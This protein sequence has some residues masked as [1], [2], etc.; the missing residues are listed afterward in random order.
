M[1]NFGKIKAIQA[2]KYISES[3]AESISKFMEIVKNSS[4]LQNEF[5]IYKSLENAHIPNE[6]LAI[7]HIDRN[8]AKRGVLSESELEKIQKFNEESISIDSTKE[9]LYESI[10]TLLHNNIDDPDI[11]HNAYMNV[12]NHIQNNKPVEIN[13]TSSF[14]LPENVNSELIIEMAVNKF[15]EKYSSMNEDEKNLFNKLSTANLEEKKQIF[16]SLKEET[17]KLTNDG[18]TN[19]IEDKINEAIESI[20]NL[21]FDEV[22]ADSSIIKLTNYKNHLLN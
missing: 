18:D 6:A 15:N 20:N 19:G 21:P 7:K 5:K 16:E 9:K 1:E 14:E 8:I 22:S 3:S 11:Q 12:L 2:T 13:E 17:I 10:H 4:K